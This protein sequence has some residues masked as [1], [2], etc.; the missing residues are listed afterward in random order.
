VFNAVGGRYICPCQDTLTIWYATAEPYLVSVPCFGVH[1]PGGAKWSHR[2]CTDPTFERVLISLT[3][4][5]H[6][7]WAMISH[8]LPHGAGVS[9]YLVHPWPINGDPSTV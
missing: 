5:G 6:L 1:D 3:S 2:H 9:G 7:T 4:H 8:G